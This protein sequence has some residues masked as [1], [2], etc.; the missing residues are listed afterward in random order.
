MTNEEYVRSKW[1][2]VLICD[3]SYRHYAKGTI[4]INWKNNGF[5]DFPNFDDAAEFTRQ[6]EG[7]IR[8][9]HEEIETLDDVQDEKLAAME[10]LDPIKRTIKR[11][12]II[13]T[14][15][16]L[17]MKEWGDIWQI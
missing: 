15:L 8:H 9:V 4:L 11:L 16:T 13:L 14:E 5:Y 3:G 12:Q 17:G 2:R 1:E 10:E 7:Y 6:R